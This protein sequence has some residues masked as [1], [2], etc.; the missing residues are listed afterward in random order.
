MYTFDLDK[1]L[2][3]DKRKLVSFNVPKFLGARRLKTVRELAAIN[4]L[5]YDYKKR[6]FLNVPSGKKVTAVKQ[7]PA[8]EQN[9]SL[10]H[11]QN[12]LRESLHDKD[13]L[14][15]TREIASPLLPQFGVNWQPFYG[16][17]MIGLSSL[18]VAADKI[19]GYNH[20]VCEATDIWAEAMETAIPESTRPGRD[21]H[22]YANAPIPFGSRK[23]S[24]IIAQ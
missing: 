15:I 9:P 13:F 18:A 17:D 24:D 20:K 16:K 1:G 5:R 3:K 22:Y 7:L 2:T 6:Y 8:A 11:R 21:Q 4:V 14:K 19:P 23:T 12:V 10:L